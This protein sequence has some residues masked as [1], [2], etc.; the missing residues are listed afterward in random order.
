MANDV[1]ART[2]LAKTIGKV[3]SGSVVC[4]GKWQAMICRRLQDIG[5]CQSITAK[6]LQVGGSALMESRVFGSLQNLCI[7]IGCKII[8]AGI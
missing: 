5:T 8:S 3:R 6:R 7:S 4:A 1:K 2:L